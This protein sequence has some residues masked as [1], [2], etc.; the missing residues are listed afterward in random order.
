MVR[1][2]RQSAELLE[3]GFVAIGWDEIGDARQYGDDPGRIRDAITRSLPGHSPGAYAAW[4]GMVR[5]FAFEMAEGDIVIAPFSEA[6]TLN[7]GIVDGPYFFA[8]AHE[9]YRHRRPVRWVKT[10]TAR[11]LFEPEALRA[12]GSI[13]TLFQVKRFENYF[14]RYLAAASDEAFQALSA[15]RPEPQ[16]EPEPDEP[17][18]APRTAA[19]TEQETEDAIIDV[20]LNKVSHEQFEHFT[21]DLLRTIGD[22]ARVTQ[23]SSDGGV[24]VIAHRDPLGL[25]PPIIK[26]QCKHTSATQG[27]PQ[28]QQLIGTLAPGE[29]GIFVTLGT[30]SKDAFAI[31]KGRRDLRLLGGAGITRLTLQNYADLP[32]QWRDLMPMRQVWV[33]E[34]DP[35]SGRS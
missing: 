4:A 31:E 30:F 14:A 27:G 25:E 29:L 6:K 32:R 13:S 8:P 20:L 24:D 26:V 28:V 12:L 35:D 34:R 9:I 1:N 15:S 21:A 23:F 18:L 17:D 16:P 11:G 33:F 3:R 2:D 5:R 22:Q 7:F 19:A 10:G